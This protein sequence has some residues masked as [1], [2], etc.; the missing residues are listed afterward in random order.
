M[1]AHHFNVVDADSDAD[2]QLKDMNALILAAANGDW[3]EA[4]S[5]AKKVMTKDPEN[6]VVS[7][8]QT[9]GFIKMQR[10]DLDT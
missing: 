4:E 3:L 8:L 5:R 2:E 1:A 6:I 9:L 10:V 7:F